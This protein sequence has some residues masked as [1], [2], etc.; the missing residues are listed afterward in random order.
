M[1]DSNHGFAGGDPFFQV[2]IVVFIIIFVSILSFFIY[3]ISTGIKQGIANKKEPILTVTAK[4]VS[5]RTYNHGDFQ[6]RY[7]TTFE[8]ESGDRMEF[9]MPID[10][11]G[12]IVEGDQ[13]E[14]TFQGYKFIEF[15]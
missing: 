10:K 8:V 4:V 5:K 9:E 12:Y 6:S 3:A 14:L 15:K 1:F 2:F 13:G 11:S 7:Y